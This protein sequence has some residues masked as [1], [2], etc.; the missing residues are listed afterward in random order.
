MTIAQGTVVRPATCDLQPRS[1]TLGIIEAGNRKYTGT[2]VGNKKAMD[3]AMISGN[4]WE[5]SLWTGEISAGKGISCSRLN[6]DSGYRH[7]GIG[8]WTQ[9][10]PNQ[11]VCKWGVATGL[12]CDYTVKAIDP[13]NGF[14]LATIGSKPGVGAD[15]HDSGGAVFQKILDSKSGHLGQVRFMGML[16]KSDQAGSTATG[17][18]KGFIF[19]PVNALLDKARWDNGAAPIPYVLP[20]LTPR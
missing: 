3:A 19:I 8:E 16:I 12:R 7:R 9:P 18:F 11:T 4:S 6:P 2:F 20:P 17:G 5:P 14:G 13:I 10:K 15:S 1:S